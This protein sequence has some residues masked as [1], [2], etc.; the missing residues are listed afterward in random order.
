MKA[1]P[2]MAYP[3]AADN[4]TTLWLK[5]HRY[6]FLNARSDLEVFGNLIKDFSDVLNYVRS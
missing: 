4:M 1:V 5:N 3:Q 2:N 6:L